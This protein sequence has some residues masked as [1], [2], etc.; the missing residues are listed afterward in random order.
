[1]YLKKWFLLLN[2]LLLVYLSA[3]SQDTV[4]YDQHEAFAPVFYPNNG[5]E[6]RTAGGTPGPQYWQN[7]ADYS[8]QANLDD[9]NQKISGNVTIT[10][11]NNSPEP[12]PFVWLQLDQNV[13]KPDSRGEATTSVSG[14]RYANLGFDG[15]YDIR[16]V[17]ILSNG[18]EENAKY[19]IS[20]TRM[21]IILASP[22]KAH[23][24]S[25]KIRIE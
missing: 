9:E 19:S 1:M 17:V 24:D 18:R 25:L 20:D 6:V 12:L 8:I 5:D 23:G 16:S 14:G 13:Y 7:E 21:Q 3:F 15:G 10:Y 11:R 22:L 4:N 2:C